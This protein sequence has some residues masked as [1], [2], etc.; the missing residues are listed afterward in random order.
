MNRI[1]TVMLCAALAATCGMPRLLAQETTEEGYSRT[2][3]MEEFTTEM[4]NN[5]P[6]AAEKVHNILQHPDYAGRLLVVCHHIG[7]LTDWLTLPEDTEYLWL[8]NSDKKFAPGLMIDRVPTLEQTSVVFGA[9]LP[10][11]EDIRAEIDKRLVIPSPVNVK[12]S[13]TVE[14]GRVTVDVEG[15]KTSEKQN[16]TMIT[17]YLVENNIN[18]D[19]Q[20]GADDGY[21]HQHVT[22]AMNKAWGEPIEWKDD[23]FTY[24]YAFDLDD[25]WKINDMEV[26][27]IVNRDLPSNVL[28]CE[29]L[30]SDAVSLGN[31]GIANVTGNSRTVAAYYDMQ[32]RKLNDR[33]GSGLYITVY[34]DGSVKKVLR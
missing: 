4:C 10:T 29:V 15:E 23:R 11:E 31:S 1:N 28:K 32:G 17:V 26:V 34:S 7:F 22:R 33:P 19:F 27:A 8:Y 13:A 16:N 6:A 20:S 21:I 18:A 3:F 24:Q 12:V 14:D 25:T 5:C 2:V 30:N 9:Y